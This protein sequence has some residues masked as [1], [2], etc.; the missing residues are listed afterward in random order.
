MSLHI[1][2][3]KEVEQAVEC[4]FKRQIE[5]GYILKAIHP[6]KNLDNK[7]LY[8]RLR[9]KNP[10]TGEKLIRPL[11]RKEGRF[12]IRE[13][14]FSGEKPN[15]ILYNLPDLNKR[16]N[17]VVIVVEGELCSDEL[18]EKGALSTTSG[19]VQSARATD[20]TI[21]KNRSI[22]IWPDNDE[23]GFKYSKDV[24]KIL[25]PFG[26]QISIIDVKDLNLSN[27]QDAVDWLN[28]NPKCNKQD[29]LNLKKVE[30]IDQ[31][32]K[33]NEIK[34]HSDHSNYSSKGYWENEINKLA[35]LPQ[36]EYEK[37]RSK[38]SKRLGVRIR[39]LDKEVEKR[40]NEI[41]FSFSN[42]KRNLVFDA[43][44]KIEPYH[45]AVNGNLL[46][47]QIKSR[48][49]A[50][51]VCEEHIAVATT[52]WCALTWF[53]DVVQ[54]MPLAI[55]TAPE[56]RCGK[57]LLL[58]MMSRFS[59]HSLLCSN[60]SPSAVFR[61]IEE[62]RPSLFID[63]ADSFF[64][65]NDELRG[66]INSGHKKKQA[67]VIR[68]VGDQHEPNR[69]S[70]WG[71]KAI[72]GIG[73]LHETILDRGIVLNL[74]RKKSNEKVQRIPLEDESID[75]EIRSKLLRFANDFGSKM[76]NMCPV[77]VKSLNDR[78]QDN[79]WNL[80]LI[81]GFVGEDWRKRTEEAAMWISKQAEEPSSKSI[82]LLYDI[83][84]IFFD[85]TS[86]NR[87]K[88]SSADLVEELCEDETKP[89]STY[90]RDKRITQKQIANLLKRFKIN[91][92]NINF[93]SQNN[94]ILK[95]YDLKSFEDVFE[96][97]LPQDELRRK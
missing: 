2:E 58:D 95:G 66:I 22:H 12:F 57:S 71:A 40:R 87:L 69:F 29:I 97:Y 70:T 20:W 74:R 48:I 51:V 43:T 53:I 49:K 45:Q 21:L 86:K 73:N 32:L 59:F 30:N 52:L 81:A 92:K 64:K 60:I 89:W 41:Q 82:Q 44:W 10:K 31:L 72:A 19:G 67:Y 17:E 15:K 94:Q 46:L 90:N 61:V 47:N 85:P 14:K 37:N 9:L 96:R 76:Q 56:K 79:W 39:I 33:N 62:Y 24:Y 91:P 5:M 38:E 55:I 80:L 34:D 13:F 88:L 3:K 84:Q 18:M 8:Y 78:A 68:N 42:S 4:L 16:K 28:K 25:E 26:C 6:Y 54:I 93:N 23:Q 1:D 63:E 83:K 65:N 27:G 50:F 35:R 36:L 7:T 11:I 75:K 77:P